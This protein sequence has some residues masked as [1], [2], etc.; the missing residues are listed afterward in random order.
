ML[1]Q[2]NP[3]LWAKAGVMLRGDTSSSAPF[4]AAY[5]TPGNGI[6]IQFR[7]ATGA[8]AQ[9][10]VRLSGQRAPARLRVGRSGNTY[11][12]Y[13]SSDGSTWTPVAGSTETL[14]LGGTVLAGLAITSHAKGILGSAT[15]D[16]VT[17]S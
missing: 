17:I 7:S 15:F 2:T 10:A 8:T 12:A 16:S 14:N 5:V 3:D 4:Y 1:S 11:T 9:E 13:T 6:S